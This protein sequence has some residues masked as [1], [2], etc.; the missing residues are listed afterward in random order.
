MAATGTRIDQA[1]DRL[2]AAFRRAGLPPVRPPSDPGPL[3]AGISAVIDDELAPFRL[4][5]Q[6]RRFWSRVDPRSLVVAP[7][8]EPVAPAF[9]LDTWRHLRDDTPGT[10]PGL[11]LPVCR[12]G[13]DLL[14][15][16]LDGPGGPGGACFT[17]AGADAPFVLEHADLAAYLDLFATMVETGQVERREA[18]G[19]SFYSFDPD[20]AWDDARRVR[21]PASVAVGRYGV[22]REFAQD[23]RD[24]PPHWLESGGAVPA[25]RRPL[26][27]DST[28][29]GLTARASALR[30]PVRGRIHARVVG[31]S[32]S[33]TGRRASIADASGLLDVWCPAGVCAFGPVLGR[34]FEFEV[35]VQPVPEA[36]RR[37]DPEEDLTARLYAEVFGT[38]RAAEASAVRPLD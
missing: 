14:L 20:E 19:R 7:V 31:L 34:S 25:D 9:A 6:L 1:V 18:Y 13:E 16:E 32:G 17:R 22:R 3:L 30:V 33:A 4:P 29:E 26:G 12:A 36:A 5:A 35:T 10:A 24:W 27:A 15:V 28:I 38:A 37:S 11:L 8:P 2:L 23:L 21:L